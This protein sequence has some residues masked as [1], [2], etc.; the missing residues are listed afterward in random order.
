MTEETRVM[1]TE[2]FGKKLRLETGRLAR[3]ASGAVLATCGGT[4]VLATVVASEDTIED[5]FLPLT[6]NYQ[7][8]SYAA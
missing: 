5:D 3:Q 8:K 4:T 7:E 6:I 1:E 2:L